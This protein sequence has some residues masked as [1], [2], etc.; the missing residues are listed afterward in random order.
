MTRSFSSKHAFTLVELLVVIAIIGILVG[1]LLP[2]VQSV[3]EVIPGTFGS[4]TAGDL[5]AR[6]GDGSIYNGDHPWAISRA[7][8]PDFQLAD[9]NSEFNSQFGSWHP[10]ICQFSMGDGSVQS[11]A[12]TIEPETLGLLAER[13]DGSV[14]F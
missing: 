11:I 4:N 1:L 10:G 9:G 2:G 14:K 5:S 12:T 7:A 6:T 8:G 3:R 13:D